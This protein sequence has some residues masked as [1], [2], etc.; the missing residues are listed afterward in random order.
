VITAKIMAAER[1][2]DQTG[3]SARLS[4]RLL[5]VALV[6]LSGCEKPNWTGSMPA[7]VTLHGSVQGGHHPIS[8]SSIQAYAAMILPHS[9]YST[10]RPIPP[11]MAAF[12]SPSPVLPQR[13]SST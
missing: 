8:G 9:H 7:F 10:S 2:L 1:I 12:P 13:R 3:C 11:T 4:L 5:I 6:I